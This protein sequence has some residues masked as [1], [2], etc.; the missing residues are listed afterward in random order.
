[1]ARARLPGWRLT[2]AETQKVVQL[3]HEGYTVTALAIR[4]GRGEAWVRGVVAN[5]AADSSTQAMPMR[6]VQAVAIAQTSL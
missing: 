2:P 4:F 5:H 3:Y 1:M 6:A